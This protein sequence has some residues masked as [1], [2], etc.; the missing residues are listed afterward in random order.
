MNDK[1]VIKGK[2]FGKGRP[3]ICLPI[4]ESEQESIIAEAKRLIDLKADVIEWRVDAFSNVS[5]L[6]AIRQVLSDLKEITEN[7]PLIYTFRSKEQGGVISLSADQIYDIHQVGAESK[8]CDLIDVEFFQTKHPAKEIKSL[9]SQGVKVIASHHDFEETPR[10]EVM[11]MLLNQMEAS[12]CD[13]VKLAVMPKDSSD[14]LALLEATNEFSKAHPNRPLI[15]MSMGKLGMV[16][17]ISGQLFGSCLTFGSAGCASAPG[18]IE[19]QK[20]GEMLDILS[21]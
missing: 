11:D 8:A 1:L 21:L 10:P 18:Q 16:S 2:T 17:R 5:S 14:V 9:Q 12:G 13:I 15:T 3:L 4:M 20:L 6:N 19:V 7:T